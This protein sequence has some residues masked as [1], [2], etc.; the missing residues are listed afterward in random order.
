MASKKSPAR[1]PIRI[2]IVGIGRAGW[3]MHCPEL[4]GRADKFAIVAACDIDPA[5][6]ARMKETY[7]CA[8][9]ANVA[10]LVADKNVELVDIATLSP[11]HTPMALKALAAGKYVFLE[12]PIAL[13][14]KDALKLKAAAAKHPGKLFL[15]HNRRFE[16]AFVHIREI[17]A[18][19]ILGN[20]YEIKLRRHGYQR[21]DDWQTLIGCGGGQLNNWGPHIIDHALQFLGSPVADVWSD[22][23]KVA[24]VGD[25]EDHLKIVLRGTNG[26]VV[27]L[28]ISGGTAIPESEYIVFGAKGALTCTGN[29]I[30][31][32][33]LDPAHKLSPRRAKRQS[34]PMEG[35]FGN[36]DQ[37]V[38]KEETLAAAPKVPCDTHNIW[39]HLHAAIRCGKKYPIT[40][41][42]AVEVVRVADLAKRGTPFAAK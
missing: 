19:G 18:S 35:S 17:I 16:T 2:G 34:P 14:H 1:T 25:A 3:G 39:D 29:T 36:P 32:K 42:E 26:R 21:R 27:D 31:M 24:A 38:W 10:D 8:T 6:R 40:V 7:G 41:D 12:K 28:E 33:Y 5:R 23:K 20:V 30:T 4:K 37:L 9:Y 15:R 13:T 22:L 11:D